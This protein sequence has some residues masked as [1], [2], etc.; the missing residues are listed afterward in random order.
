MSREYPT[1]QVVVGILEEQLAG[2]ATNWKPESEEG[3]GEE[4]E[5]EDEDKRKKWHP[6]VA[7]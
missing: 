2:N 7:L 3:E 6:Q 1:Q 5:E 4:E